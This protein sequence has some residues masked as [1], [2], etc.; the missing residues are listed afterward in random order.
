MKTTCLR[1]MLQWW[2]CGGPISDVFALNFRPDQL[3]II[4]MKYMRDEDVGRRRV[5]WNNQEEWKWVYAAAVFCVGEK[6]FILPID[7]RSHVNLDMF[8]LWLFV[9]YIYFFSDC[10]SYRN[11]SIVFLARQ[12]KN[13]S[14][15][16]WVRMC[17]NVSW[18]R[19]KAVCY[20]WSFSFMR[21]CF[22]KMY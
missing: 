15:F 5:K 16:F 14:H 20:G 21:C 7:F 10:I 19:K 4:Y 1:K 2:W 18:F 17:T 22:D 6:S 11:L 9:F 13:S 3:P 8:I 12:K